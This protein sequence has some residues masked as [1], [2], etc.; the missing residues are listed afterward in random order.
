MVSFN[1]KLII[2]LD[3]PTYFFKIFKNHCGDDMWLP[4]ML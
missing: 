4:Q 1:K 3:G 2:Y